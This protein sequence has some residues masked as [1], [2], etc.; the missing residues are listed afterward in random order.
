[1]NYSKVRYLAFFAFFMFCASFAFAQEK[2]VTNNE[3]SSQNLSQSQIEEAQWSFDD[4]SEANANQE[5]TSVNG[6]WVFIR[7]VIVLAIVIAVIY[8]IF[9]FMKRTIGPAA[10]NDPFLRKV[11]G[12]NLAPGKSVQ[13]V[14]LVDKGFILGVS[15]D[16][17]NLLCEIQD[18]ELIN[19]MN[20]HS[21]KTTSQFKAKNFAEVL[22]MFMPKKRA[23]RVVSSN[24]ENAESAFDSSTQ[25]LINSIKQ[26]RMNNSDNENMQSGVEQ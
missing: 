2:S 24:N 21:D 16:S 7:M 11:A 1:M 14:T 5:N 6:F 13:V 10:D 26:K 25:N 12:I 8:L 23:E 15:D 18:K 9:R 17:V 22:E 19:A 3:Q 20:V 4:A